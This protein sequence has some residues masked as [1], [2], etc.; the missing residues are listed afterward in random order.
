MAKYNRGAWFPNP[1]PV[2]TPEI[3]SGVESSLYVKPQI[4]EKWHTS[5]W[6]RSSVVSHVHK[7]KDSVSDDSAD[8]KYLSSHNAKTA[9]K[10]IFTPDKFNELLYTRRSKIN[11]DQMVPVERFDK[12]IFLG[13][14]FTKMRYLKRCLFNQC[15]FIDNNFGETNPY[16]VMFLN[17]KFEN[18]DF[19]NAKM[20]FTQMEGCTFC[21]DNF[22]GSQWMSRYWR[23]PF[24]PEHPNKKWRGKLLSDT[25]ADKDKADLVNCKF[26]ECSFAGSR[27]SVHVANTVFDQCYGPAILVDKE[28]DN[29]PLFVQKYFGIDMS[30]SSDFQDIF[31]EN[32]YC[33]SRKM[34]LEIQEDLQRSASNI[35]ARGFIGIHYAKMEMLL[36]DMEKDEINRISKKQLEP[37]RRRQWVNK[38]GM[39]D[40]VQHC[41]TRYPRTSKA[42]YDSSNKYFP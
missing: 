2:E 4:E 25:E 36:A 11:Y 33:L 20:S 22:N 8:D 41:D 7:G 14:D 9:K 35:S 40:W 5:V 21:G 19:T 12:C 29:Q 37:S 10:V 13:C 28:K 38:E 1:S 17:C 24:D 34:P 31:K 27:M 32:T 15:V 3:D 18:N 30:R 42:S 39:A 23:P 6:N 16:N 26:H